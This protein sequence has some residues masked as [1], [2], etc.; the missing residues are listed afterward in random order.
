MGIV[1]WRQVA[2]G[3]AILVAGDDQGG[4]MGIAR[5]CV[6]VGSAL[7]PADVASVHLAHAGTWGGYRPLL[8]NLPR[9]VTMI[10][11][12]ETLYALAPQ[13]A[14]EQLLTRTP[15]WWRHIGALAEDAASQ[16]LDAMAYLLMQ[17]SKRRVLTRRSAAVGRLSLR[18]PF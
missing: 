17:D 5:G 11:R 9:R 8:V 2:P 7:G 6:E 15:L 3:A 12:T 16:A 13:I 10:A 18:R 14:M 4:L 1:L